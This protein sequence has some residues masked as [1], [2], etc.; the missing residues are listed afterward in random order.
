MTMPSDDELAVI[1]RWTLHTRWGVGGFMG[2]GG[3]DDFTCRC[4]SCTSARQ[5]RWLKEIKSD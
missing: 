3:E 1:Y 4:E 2:V 5:N